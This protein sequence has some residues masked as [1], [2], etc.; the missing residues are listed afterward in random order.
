MGPR[1][2]GLKLFIALLLP[3]VVIFGTIEIC[4]RLFAAGDIAFFR[5]VVGETPTHIAIFQNPETAIKKFQFPKNPHTADPF[6]AWKNQV[7]FRQEPYL[8][9]SHGIYS[10]HEISYDRGAKTYRLLI[11]GD[12]STAGLGIDKQADTWPQVLQGLLP[13][14][15]EVVNAAVI[16]YSSEQARVALAREDY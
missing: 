7:N 16:G 4:I 2:D 13:D 3:F 8:T 14:K 11:L 9:T 5:S 6:L 10:P 15:V 1:G 12:S